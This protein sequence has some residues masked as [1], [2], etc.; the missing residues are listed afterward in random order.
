MAEPTRTWGNRRLAALAVLVLAALAALASWRISP[1]HLPNAVKLDSGLLFHGALGV[2]LFVILY[3]L[4]A[5]VT[6]TIANGGPPAKMGLGNANFDGTAG[7]ALAESAQSLRGI[8]E[9]LAALNSRTISLVSVSRSTQEALIELADS[10]T[11]QSVRDAAQL[12][13]KELDEI[14]ANNYDSANRRTADAV[15]RF[16]A[17]LGEMKV[18]LGNREEENA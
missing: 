10:S 18:A 6:T 16:E 11:R 17:K 7:D 1:K 13:I 14:E 2:V 3:F 15:A 12:R 5:L 9:Q 4:A 8:N